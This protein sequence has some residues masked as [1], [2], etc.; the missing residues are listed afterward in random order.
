MT[1]HIRQVLAR[2]DNFAVLLHDPETGATAAIDAPEAEAIEEMLAETGWQLTHILVTHEHFDHVEG[3]EPLKTKYRCTVVA[4]AKAAR[5]PLVDRTVVEGDTVSIGNV[6]LAV[7][8]TPGH[9]PDHV[10]YWSSPEKVVFVGDTLFALGCGRMFNSTPTEFW[11]SL[12]KL[13]SLPDDTQVYCGHEYTL[14]NARF[15]VSVDPTNPALRARV[16]EVEALR[17]NGQVT[18]PTSIGIERATNPFL[19]A[20]DAAIR[21]TLGL[22]GAAAAEVFAELRERKNRF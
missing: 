20:E 17:A 1:A 13:A 8:E 21:A 15:A 6:S 9:C 19:R 4:P 16:S 18:L 5:V 11:T 22:T 10:A 2:S 3:I 7:I 12:Q 14:A